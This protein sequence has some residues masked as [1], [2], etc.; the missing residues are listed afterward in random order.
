VNLLRESIEQCD[1]ILQRSPVRA[2][3]GNQAEE[4]INITFPCHP[5]PATTCVAFAFALQLLK[6]E[7]RGTTHIVAEREALACSI[8][9]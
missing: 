2:H 1:D 6:D 3:A 4:E 8:K 5:T 7:V 9:S